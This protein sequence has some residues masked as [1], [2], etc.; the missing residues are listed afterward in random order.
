VENAT[1]LRLGNQHSSEEEM[2]EHLSQ[3][4]ERAEVP[5]RT[6]TGVA[7][8]KEVLMGGNAIVTSFNKPTHWEWQWST[9]KAPSFYTPKLLRRL[10]EILWLITR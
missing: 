2:N 7:E 8:E 4:R 6:G 9:I 10:K 3:G 5:W 1:V